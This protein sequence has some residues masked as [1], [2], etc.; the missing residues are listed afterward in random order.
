MQ[1]E[2]AESLTGL[3]SELRAELCGCLIMFLPCGPIRA[4]KLDADISNAS[5][6]LP[7]KYDSSGAVKRSG[8]GINW[9]RQWRNTIIFLTLV[10]YLL[11][12][13]TL[14]KRGGVYSGPER[15]ALSLRALSRETWG[16]RTINM[17]FC[18]RC[19]LLS[20]HDFNL[21]DNFRG[22]SFTQ[23]IFKLC[24]WSWWS[25]LNDIMTYCRYT[26]QTTHT[27]AHTYTHTT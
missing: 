16:S 20:D 2:H 7:A 1:A 21:Q 8:R 10:F 26:L 12:R 4:W 5:S 14:G 9:G 25:S 3:I 19:R 15:L 6:L 22:I 17:L 18:N 27:H 24:F 11:F 13:D 23:I